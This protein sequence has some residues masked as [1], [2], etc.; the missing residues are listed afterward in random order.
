MTGVVDIG[1]LA[2]AAL[3]DR[4]GDPAAA[5]ARASG[6]RATPSRCPVRR[7]FKGTSTCSRAAASSQGDFYSEEAGLDRYRFPQ[8]QGH[9]V[10]TPNRV[11]VTDARSKL[12]RRGRAVHATRCRCSASRR[13]PA[14]RFDATY[15][16]RQPRAPSPTPME[17][18]GP[19]PGRD[20]SAGSNLLEW[21]L[22][23]WD[24]HHGHG[25]RHGRRRRR[26]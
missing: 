6:G 11:E 21:R 25:D 15:T 1:A 24:E 19:P 4:L 3:R 9:V 20:A 23:H 22:G 16:R 12:L 17:M 14:V 13:R 2:R 7:R 8:L 26:A 10:W 18:T 5:H